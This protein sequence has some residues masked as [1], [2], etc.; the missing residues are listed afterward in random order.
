MLNTTSSLTSTPPTLTSTTTTPATSLN[1][2]PPSKKIIDC[3]NNVCINPKPYIIA[4]AYMLAG[5][6]VI[7]LIYSFIRLV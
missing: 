4:L 7:A 1:D 2:T 3:D 5:V 6:A